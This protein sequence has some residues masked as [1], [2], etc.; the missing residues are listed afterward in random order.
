MDDAGAIAVAEHAVRYELRPF[1]L[2]PDQAPGLRAHWRD[3]AGL[4]DVCASLGIAQP[5]TRVVAT[6]QEVGSAV[7]ALG[8]P[9]VAKVGPAVAAPPGSGNCATPA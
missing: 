7:A 1:F 3:K 5:E 4:A 9:L 6:E 2:L 8:L